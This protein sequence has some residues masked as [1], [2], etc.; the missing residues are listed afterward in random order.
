MLSEAEV[1]KVLSSFD[2]RTT[3]GKRDYAV[4]LCFAELGLRCCEIAE[5][6]IDDIDW[7]S[8]N[9][10]VPALKA[11]RERVMPLLYRTGEAI[12]AYLQASRPG[13]EPDSGKRKLFLRHHGTAGYPTGRGVVRGIV[14]RAFERCEISLPKH[15]GPH[16]FRHTMAG[17]MIRQ[18]NG[19]KEIADML[20]HKSIETAMIYTKVDLT[21]LEQVA[22]EWPEANK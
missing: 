15:V 11:R 19:I 20:G 12:A 18:G 4:A 14:R 3:V 2:R 8:G 6:S 22:L 17:K 9:I 7:S 13:R 1:E 16:V 5:L 10:T 21:M